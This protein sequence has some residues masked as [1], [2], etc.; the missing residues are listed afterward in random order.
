[1]EA[2]QSQRLSSTSPKFINFYVRLRDKDVRGMI[3]FIRFNQVCLLSYFSL[4]SFKMI[5]IPLKHQPDD[6][7]D[8]LNRHM[9]LHTGAFKYIYSCEFCDRIVHFEAQTVIRKKKHRK[10]HI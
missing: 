7:K 3:S 6:N 1:M 5:R 4:D 8:S 9:K 10:K 2:I